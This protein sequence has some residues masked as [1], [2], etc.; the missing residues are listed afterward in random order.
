MIMITKRFVARALEK[1]L[2]YG[3]TIICVIVVFLFFCFLIERIVVLGVTPFL[4]A[5]GIIAIISVVGTII[6]KLC[7]RLGEWIQDNRD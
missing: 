7:C 2:F 1:I 6:V 4:Q 5:F 3:L